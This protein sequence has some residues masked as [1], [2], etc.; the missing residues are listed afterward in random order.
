MEIT[1]KGLTIVTKEG[2]TR[3][4]E[5]DNV[6]PVL[7]FSPNKQMAEALKDKVAEIYTI[8]DCDDPAVIPDATAAGWRVGNAI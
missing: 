7:P 6:M 5:A 4:L 2:E 1:K 3:L 8:G